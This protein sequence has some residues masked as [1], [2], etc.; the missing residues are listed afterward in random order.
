[1]IFYFLIIYIKI[2]DDEEVDIVDD[3]DDF[4]GDEDDCFCFVCD[5][6]FDNSD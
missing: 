6:F 3:V 2:D 1:M 5:C 4:E